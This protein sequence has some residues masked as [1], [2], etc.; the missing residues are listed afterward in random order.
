[1]EKENFSSKMDHITKAPSRTTLPK[2]KAGISSITVAS[3]KAISITIKQMAKA[4]I[5][6]PSKIINMLANGET[7]NPMERGSK[8]LEMVAIMRDLSKAELK[9]DLG[10]MYANLE[11]TRALLNMATFQ[12]KELLIILIIEYIRGLGMMACSLAMAFLHG[13]TAISTKAS[14]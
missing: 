10:I 1:M 7:T 3:T 5:S 12:E 4:P 13:Q 8:S 14:I 11:S 6:I 9:M 2:D